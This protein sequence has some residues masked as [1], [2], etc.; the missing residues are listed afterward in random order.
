MSVLPSRRR[1][2]AVGAM[3]VAV[4]AALAST[5]ALGGSAVAAPAPVSAADIAANTDYLGWH[6]EKGTGANTLNGLAIGAGADSY[7]LNGLVSTGAPGLVT[8]APG[9]ESLITGT[10]VVATGDVVLQFPYSVTADGAPGTIVHWGTLRTAGAVAS[11][12]APSATTQFVSSKDLPGI[13]NNTAAPLSAFLEELVALDLT[14]DIRYSGYGFWASP[15]SP[16]AEVASI[17]FNGATTAFGIPA[18]TNVAP[19]ATVTVPAADIRPNEDTYPGWHEGQ[20]GATPFSVDAAGLHLGGATASQIINGLATPKAV[21]SLDALVALVG[22]YGFDVASGAVHAQLP[23]FY[24]AADS[25]TT[26]RTAAPVAAGEYAPTLTEEWMSS[27][28]IP[29]TATTPAIARNTAVPL[30][31]L[32]DALAAQGNIRALAFGVYAGPAEASALVS[33]VSFDG[34]K[35]VFGVV[36]AETTPPTET[37]TTPVATTPA[38]TTPA[39]TKA[40]GKELADSGSESVWLTVAAGSMLAL[41]AVGVLAARRNRAGLEH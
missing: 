20:A 35:Y 23:F 1:N 39:A 19:T 22:T 26:L 16:A 37:T 30:A 34:T 29:A 6:F 31:T 18:L 28:D 11:G 27:R 2:G 17:T 15:Q 4:V 33:S 8:S 41:G 38:A 36:A 3:A 24:G 5:F 25:F 7:A 14:N 12:T 21:G 13:P 9:L 32:L 10:S 40:P